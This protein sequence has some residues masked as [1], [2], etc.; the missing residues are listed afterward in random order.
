LNAGWNLVGYPTLNGS[1]TISGALWGTGADMAEGFDSTSP[2][3]KML[4]PSYIMKPGEGY[5]IHVPS[6]TVWVINW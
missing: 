6:D 4:E 3:I 2:Y 5:W 1:V